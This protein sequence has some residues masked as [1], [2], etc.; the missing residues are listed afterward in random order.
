MYIYRDQMVE[1]A[2]APHPI[3]QQTMKNKKLMSHTKFA[4]KTSNNKMESATCA[5][6]L[7]I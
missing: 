4:N 3:F 7:T 5:R 6:L 2:A 1:N